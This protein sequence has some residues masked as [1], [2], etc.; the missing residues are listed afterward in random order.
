MNVDLGIWDKLSKLITLLLVV[1]GLVA[2]AAWYLPVIEQNEKMR[3]QLLV[4]EEEIRNEEARAKKLKA[5]VDAMRDPRTIE[6][7]ARERLSFARSGET[8]IRF[9]SAGATNVAASFAPK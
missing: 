5:E 8:V 7:L 1:A 2:V 4:L 3:R 6:R 9:E